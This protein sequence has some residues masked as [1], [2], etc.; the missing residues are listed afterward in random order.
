MSALKSK[1]KQWVRSIAGSPSLPT[2]RTRAWRPDWLPDDYDLKLES[3]VHPHVENER[4]TAFLAYNAGT[5]EIEVLHWLHATICV[6]K[7]NSILETGAAD[8]LGTLAL[9]AACRAN[10]LGHVHSVEIVPELCLKLDA[11]LHREGLEDFATVHC[12][13]SLEFLEHTDLKFDFAFFD[14]LCEI[15]ADEYAICRRRHLLSGMAVFHDTSPLRTLSLTDAPTSE[16]HASFRD[17]LLAYALDPQVTGYHEF[18][19]SRGMIAIFGIDV[20]A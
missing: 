19:L 5:T 3:E 9:A 18:R 12:R 2:K 16:L 11:L 10:A 17:K 13:S 1:I 20:V 8:G 14:S 7:P 15:R 4:A 6:A